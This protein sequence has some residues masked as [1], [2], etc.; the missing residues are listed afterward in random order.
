MLEK[1]QKAV[2][3]LDHRNGVV[4]DVYPYR[5]VQGTHNAEL[6]VNKIHCDIGVFEN[7]TVEQIKYKIEESINMAYE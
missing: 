5:T 2:K 3:I 7:N 1:I 4:I 6:I